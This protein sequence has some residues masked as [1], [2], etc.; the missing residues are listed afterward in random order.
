[1]PSRRRSP[2]LL[3]SKWL[4]QGNWT[5]SAGRQRERCG[6]SPENAD[7]FNSRGGVRHSVESC[8]ER[9]RQWLSLPSLLLPFRHSAMNFCLVFP[10]LLCEFTLS[11]MIQYRI[12][13]TGRNLSRSRASIMPN[14]LVMHLIIM[15]CSSKWAFSFNT[16][17]AWIQ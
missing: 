2:F 7:F 17:C 6:S 12:Y 11:R 14:V 10:W 16:C 13:G 15:F 5:E 4:A 3:Y 8:V 9:L 1:M